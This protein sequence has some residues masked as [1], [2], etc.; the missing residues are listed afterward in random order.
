MNFMANGISKLENTIEDFLRTKANG[1]VLNLGDD[2]KLYY[3]K[4][5]VDT[6]FITKDIQKVY[7]DRNIDFDSYFKSLA[8]KVTL[9]ET[10]ESIKIGIIKGDILGIYKN[11]P[12]KIIGADKIKSRG[13]PDVERESS[14]EGGMEGFNEVTS[15]NVNLVAQYYRQPALVVKNFAVGTRSH[16]TVALLYDSNYVDENLLKE[17]TDRLN[18][19]NVPAVQSLNGLQQ[20]LWKKQL[21]IPRMLVTQRPDRVTE[22]LTKGKIVLFLDGTATAL[23]IPVQFHDFMKTVDDEY[24]LPIPALFLMILRYLALLLSIILP[25]AYV[26]IVSYNPEI[27]RI[28]LSLSISSSR[29]GVPYPSFIEVFIMLLLMEFLVEASLRLPK[30]IG[31][32]ATTVGG[33]ILGQA[34]IQAHLVSNIMIIIVST[35][36]ISNFMIPAISMNLSVRVAKYGLLLLSSFTGVYGI[37]LGLYCL[38]CYMFSLKTFNIPYFNPVE[39]MSIKD[40]K[41]FFRKGH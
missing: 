10:L 39:N 6:D 22:Y 9:N 32:A 37:Y 18:K 15:T 7:F 27:M 38:V 4:T 17:I 2:F 16:N 14:F 30:S 19:I 25:S 5:L 11:Q 35:V 20:L 24:L 34:A 33:L 28:Q 1:E 12:Y 29:S 21:L 3:I 40:I 8:T 36:A 26:A 13:V 31:Q 41:S 23:I